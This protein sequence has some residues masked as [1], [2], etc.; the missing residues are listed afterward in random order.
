MYVTYTHITESKVERQTAIAISTFKIEML[1]RKDSLKIGGW[2][3]NVY[4]SGA[5]GLE[6]K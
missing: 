3:A 5:E 6:I 2:H 4:F 1:L